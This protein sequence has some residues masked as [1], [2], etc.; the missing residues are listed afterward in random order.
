VR[1][2]ADLWKGSG[3]E[4]DDIHSEF[5]CPAGGARPA[6]VPGH[7]TRSWL[8]GIDRACVKELIAYGEIVVVEIARERRVV[9]GSIIDYVARL[10]AASHQH[11]ETRPVSAGQVSNSK[12]DGTADEDMRHATTRTLPYHRPGG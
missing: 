5:P 10:A 4:P 11:A 3:H 7:G 12:A 8:L 2:Q 6:P 9:V 1:R